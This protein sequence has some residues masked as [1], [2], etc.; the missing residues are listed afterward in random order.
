MLEEFTLPDFTRAFCNQCARDTNHEI[1]YPP[2][3]YKFRDAALESDLAAGSMAVDQHGNI[4]ATL[5]GDPD[6]EAWYTTTIELL[7]C[8][9]CDYGTVR[10]KICMGEEMQSEDELKRDYGNDSKDFL[11]TVQYPPVMARR[12]PGWLLSEAAGA[13]LIPEKIRELMGEI[14]TALQ[15]GS[16]RLVG[17]GTRA[18]L[19]NIITNK[20]KDRGH[21]K[22]NLDAFVE[23]GYLSSRQYHTVDITFHAGSAS[24]H[25]GWKPSDAN[26]A[27]IMDII[28]SVIET[29]YLHERRGRGLEKD[30]PKR[31]PRLQT[32]PGGPRGTAP[33]EQ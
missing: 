31:P 32:K 26:V 16:R 10:Q 29:T 22:T 23:A 1:L 6:F 12:K 21:F 7:K 2:Y 17:I 13:G 30:V 4:I 18:V 8:S 5:E 15:N 19:E 11:Q 28:E 24:M 14:Y 27:D 33:G 25:R 3:Q 9:G 20:I